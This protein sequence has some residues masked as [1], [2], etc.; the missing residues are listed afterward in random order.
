MRPFLV[1]NPGSRNRKSRRIIE[2]YKQLLDARGV[3]YGWAFTQDLEH[4][5]DLAAGAAAS[6]YQ[7]I[8]AVGGDGT[9][10]RVINGL[11]RDG[12]PHQARA[13]GVLYAGTSPDF[14]RHYGIPLNPE[15]AV[16]AFLAGQARTIDVC[17]ICM[18]NGKGMQVTAYFASS[19]NIGL[20][21]RIA[22]GANRYRKLLGDFSGTL[23]ATLVAILQGHQDAMNLTTDSGQ[24]KLERVWNITVGK[25]PHLASG[26]RLDEAV[27]PRDGS[28]YLFAVHNAGPSYLLSLLPKAYNGSIS[29]E[30]G[31]LLDNLTRVEVTPDNPAVRAELDG[32]PAGSGP[33]HI[34]VVK[35]A[36]RLIS[37][38]CPEQGH[39]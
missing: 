29:G 24:V 3:D 37:T 9:I 21:P 27:A 15:A 8:V 38:A 7:A 26:L 35:D 5:A 25:N 12:I 6:G 22:A 19:A 39:P 4:A 18:A 34:E 30:Q 20:G 33:F 23:L 10:N 16:D 1:C 14:C 28:M 11:L 2:T 36:L 17:R 13:L 31:F 32:D